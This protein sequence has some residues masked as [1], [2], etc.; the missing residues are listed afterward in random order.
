MKQESL[1]GCTQLLHP[2]SKRSDNWERPQ[3]SGPGALPTAL[4]A[5]SSQQEVYFVYTV[6]AFPPVNRNHLTRL[7]ID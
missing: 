1:S 5:V 3:A 7:R 2:T 6:E 4:V